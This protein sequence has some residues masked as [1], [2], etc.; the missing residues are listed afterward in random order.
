MKKEKGI[1]IVALTITVIVLIILASISV[2]TLKGNEGSINRAKYSAFATEVTSYQKAIQEHIV[3]KQMTEH[4]N[5]PVNAL[6]VDEVKLILKGITDET[7]EKFVIQDNELRYVPDKV[8][9][10]EKEWLEEL[11]IDEMT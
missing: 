8:D 2:G 5:E 4:T 11:E 6:A 10:Q 9:E 3:K 1:T 7:A